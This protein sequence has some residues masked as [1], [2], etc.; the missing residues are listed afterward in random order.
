MSDF[1]PSERS[2]FPLPTKELA[3]EL[4]KEVRHAP[5][6]W[7]PLALPFAGAF[8]GWLGA[9]LGLAVGAFWWKRQWPGWLAKVQAEVIEERNEDEHE[10]LRKQVKTLARFRCDDLADSLE[11]FVRLKKEI[12]RSIHRSPGELTSSKVETEKLVDALCFEVAD[13]LRRIAD[14]RYTLK[15]RK[16]RRLSEEKV[17][18]LKASEDQLRD[19]VEHAH[20]TLKEMHANLRVVLDPVNVAPERSSALEETIAKLKEETAIARRVRERIE[21]DNAADLLSEMSVLEHEESQTQARGALV[22]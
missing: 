21:R 5:T 17:R 11:R 13:E 4:W 8:L 3:E 19:R 22:E 10:A 6:F 1:K 15:K 20:E 14:I 12:E 2:T 16:K 18:E 7:I 9:A